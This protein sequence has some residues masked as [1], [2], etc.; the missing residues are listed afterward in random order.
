MGGFSGVQMEF[1]SPLLVVRSMLRVLFVILYSW[2]SFWFCSCLLLWV[3]FVRVGCWFSFTMI[4]ASLE[5]VLKFQ[6]VSSPSYRFGAAFGLAALASKGW[7]WESMSLDNQP[8]LP[9]P[10][11]MVV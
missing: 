5:F 7:A 10:L 2:V 3:N 9:F 11:I 8:L 4:I 6:V 1:W